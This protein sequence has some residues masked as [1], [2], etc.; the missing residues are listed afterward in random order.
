MADS[1]KCPPPTGEDDQ[2][3]SEEFAHCRD[4]L[5]REIEEVDPEIV[6]ALGNRP[7]TRTLDVLN[8][9]AVDMGTASHAG[10]RFATDPP[11]LISTSWPY[12][13]LFERS[14]DQYWGGDWVELQPELRDATW[15]SYLEIVQTSLDTFL[16]A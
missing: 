10:R 12:G 14:P 11:L 4:Y 7:A 2:K 6:V 8:G 1:V 15:D 16:N 13:W 9:P 5:V 3:R